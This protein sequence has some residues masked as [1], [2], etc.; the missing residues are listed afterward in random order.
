[1]CELTSNY[2]LLIHIKCLIK[3]L[4]IEFNDEIV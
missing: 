2:Q 3:F 1:M 4:K